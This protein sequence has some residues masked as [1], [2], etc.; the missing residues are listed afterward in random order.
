MAKESG[1]SAR[2]GD[3]V[4]TPTSSTKWKV[5][6]VGAP[7]WGAPLT[8]VL[9]SLKSGRT[10]YAVAHDYVIVSRSF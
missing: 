9:E 1:T 5:V 7:V 4:K 3:I 2:E 10:R 8:L 6:E